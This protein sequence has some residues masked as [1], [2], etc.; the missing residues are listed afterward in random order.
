MSIKKIFLP[1]DRVNGI[2]P[3][4]LG[5]ST[6]NLNTHNQSE[7]P[8]PCEDGVFLLTMINFNRRKKW[9]EKS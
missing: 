7:L 5:H 2:K 9:Q 1:E 6:G 8:R 3:L 4:N